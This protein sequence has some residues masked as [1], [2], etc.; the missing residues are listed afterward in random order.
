MISARMLS[1]RR[2]RTFR[3][4]SSCQLKDREGSHCRTCALTAT[5]F[6]VQ[7]THGGSRRGMVT[8][9]RARRSSV[10]GGARL[11]AASA[12]GGPEQSVGCTRQCGSQRGEVVCVC[13]FSSCCRTSRRASRRGRRYVAIPHQHRQSGGRHV[14]TTT[15]GRRLARVGRAEFGVLVIQVRGDE[16]GSHRP[17]SNL[18]Q[19]GRDVVEDVMRRVLRPDQRAEDRRS[20][21]VRQGFVIVSF[22]TEKQLVR[23]RRKSTECRHVPWARSS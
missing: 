7:I 1:C 12:T 6:C 11:V 18:K 23:D 15:C 3:G 8:A 14:G 4:G 10:T 2:A 20:G 17:S 22:G 9:A 5:D 16:Q 19:Q 21:G 13:V